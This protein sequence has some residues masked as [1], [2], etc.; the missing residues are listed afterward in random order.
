M[1][2]CTCQTRYTKEKRTPYVECVSL[3]PPVTV[4]CN[5]KEAA[6]KRVLFFMCLEVKGIWGEQDTSTRTCTLCVCSVFIEYEEKWNKGSNC[7]CA[8]WN[9]T[10]WRRRGCGCMAPLILKCRAGQMSDTFY[11]PVIL[12]LAKNHGFRWR[13]FHGLLCYFGALEK[14]KQ[15]IVPVESRNTIPRSSNP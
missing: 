6:P 10:R 4:T 5:G 3:H 14:E 7:P 12:P 1:F 9:T 2:D 13:S 15:S 11:A 8:S